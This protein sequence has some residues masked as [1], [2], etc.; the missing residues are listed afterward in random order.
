MENPRIDQQLL[1]Q[2]CH[3][4]DSSL[5]FAWLG[6]GQECNIYAGAKFLNNSVNVMFI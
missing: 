1:L 5:T 3:N 4:S 6:L 2:N